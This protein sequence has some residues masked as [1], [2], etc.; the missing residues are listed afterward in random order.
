MKLEQKSLKL[1]ALVIGM[2]ALLRLAGSGA[3]T[4]VLQLLVQPETVSVLMFMETGRVV[5]PLTTQPDA[6]EVTQP[7][8]E[9]DAGLTPEDAALVEV[10][11]VCGYEVDLQSMLEMPL[12]WDL[13]QP[14][15]TVLILHSHGTE[16]YQQTEQYQE[17]SPYRTLDEG[18]NVVSVGRRIAQILEAGGV[19][20]VHD[21]TLHDYPS[22]SGAYNSARQ[23]IEDYM[24]DYPTIRLVL[25]IHRD[26]VENNA[27]E[28]IRYT[29]Q[30]GGETVAQVM[31]VVGTDASGLEH[32]N[33]RENMALAVKL[34]AQLEKKVPG[35]CRPISFRSQRFNQDMSSGALLIEMGS[36]GNTRQEAMLAAERTASAILS[37]AKGTQ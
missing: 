34:H 36:A 33:W 16:S 15:P 20:V 23:A 12:A 26:S 32:P 22:Y 7:P 30:D 6:T 3:L 25:D 24:E 4:P 29:V 11:S 2:A 17:S 19:E 14:G 21:T 10:N 5:R 18:Y 8:E 27:G 13:T 31:L 9:I 1:G 28:Q 35:I 37:L